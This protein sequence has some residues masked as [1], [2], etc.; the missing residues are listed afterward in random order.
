MNLNNWKNMQSQMLY[1]LC[2]V[3][4]RP[5]VGCN[6]YRNFGSIYWPIIAADYLKCQL[7]TPVVWRQV[8]SL[9]KYQSVRNM[10]S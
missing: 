7:K 8:I 9:A 6:R 5:K 10:N 4:I 1:I 2:L 3:E